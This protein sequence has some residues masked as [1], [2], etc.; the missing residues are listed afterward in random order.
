MNADALR[1]C[2]GGIQ[3]TAS[4]IGEADA[5]KVIDQGASTPPTPCR[6]A[7]LKRV[8]GVNT[9]EKTED[10]TLIQT[11]YRIPETRWPKIRF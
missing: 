10:A 9:T 4:V 6:S 3:I 11:R 8:T 7:I 2:T 1:L 5:L